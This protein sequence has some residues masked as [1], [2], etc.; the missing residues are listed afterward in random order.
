MRLFESTIKINDNRIIRYDIFDSFTE[1]HTI[2]EEFINNNRVIKNYKLSRWDDYSFTAWIST[3]MENLEDINSLSYDFD[4]NHPLY[5][6]LLHLLDGDNELLIDDDETREINKKY[7]LINKDNDKINLIF[8]NNLE[9]YDVLNK[10]YV[11]VKNIGQDPRSKITDI[12]LK[13]R[14]FEFYKEVY[15]IFNNKIDEKKYLKK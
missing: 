8:V 1:I 11:F 2:K 10:F 7:M 12:E 14:L 13:K 9:Y 3:A 6:P 4:I 5:N 15:Q